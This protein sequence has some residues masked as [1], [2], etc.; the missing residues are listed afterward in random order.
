MLDYPD[1]LKMRVSDETIYQSLFVQGSGALR[2]ELTRCLR[3]RRAQRR[4]L[5]RA[6]GSGQLQ[7]MVLMS[8]RRADGEDRAVPGHWEGDL[9]HGKRAQ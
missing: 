7:H 4:P 3:T 9:I 5:G 1:D 8:E 6:T 2:Q